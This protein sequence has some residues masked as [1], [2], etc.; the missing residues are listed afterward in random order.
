MA[1]A[2][3]ART[4][5][6]VFEQRGYLTL[7]EISEIKECLKTSN[8]VRPQSYYFFPATSRLALA[9]SPPLSAAL[10]P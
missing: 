4:L 2:L 7:P 10:S 3:I 9:M 5:S 1:D 8:G 6:V